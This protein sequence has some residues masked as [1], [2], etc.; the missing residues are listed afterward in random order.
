MSD[1]LSDWRYANLRETDRALYFRYSEFKPE[2]HGDHDHCIG[3]W[4]KI[5]GKEFPK[6]EHDGYIARCFDQN[7]WVC[8]TCW[9]DFQKPLGWIEVS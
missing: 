8:R 2:V 7:R 1:L 5:A 3:C 9:A 4:Q 6:A